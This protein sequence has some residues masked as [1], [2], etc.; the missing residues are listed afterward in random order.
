MD[1]LTDYMKEKR[2]T[3]AMNLNNT[4]PVFVRGLSFGVGKHFLPQAKRSAGSCQV[5]GKRASVAI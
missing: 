3:I 5:N 4:I 2:S 1:D